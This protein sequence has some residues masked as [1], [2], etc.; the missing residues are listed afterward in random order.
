MIVN[1][2]SKKEQ[3]IFEGEL[4]RIAFA[5][6]TEGQNHSGFAKEVSCRF[7]PGLEKIGKHDLGT[8][9]THTTPQGITFF[10]LVCYSINDGWNVGWNKNQDEIIKKCFD[11][12]ESN[13]PIAAVNI[14]TE[15]YHRLCGSNPSLI[16]KGMELS[17]KKIIVYY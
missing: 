2:E 12:I 17:E 11:S 15:C 8:I 9:L 10:A 14:G 4:R 7:W 16:K 1:K 13:E 5:I 6:N 3:D